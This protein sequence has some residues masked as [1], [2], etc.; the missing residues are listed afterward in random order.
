MNLRDE[1]GSDRLVKSRAF[2]GQRGRDR[3]RQASHPLVHVE[4]VFQAADCDWQ[5]HQTGNGNNRVGKMLGSRL[6][7]PSWF[8]SSCKCS[9]R[10]AVSIYKRF[11][12][13]STSCI[14]CNLTALTVRTMST[15]T[16]TERQTHLDEV[17]KA[18]VRALSIPA[19]NLKGFLRV[20]AM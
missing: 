8:S 19:K 18:V 5:R 10:R 1:Y 13:I 20:T 9:D 17:P 16:Q 15:P 2:Q 6:E 14:S 3:Q 12:Y 4:I 7:I 11:K